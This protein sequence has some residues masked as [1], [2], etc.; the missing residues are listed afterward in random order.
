MENKML[1]IVPDEKYLQ[2]DENGKQFYAY[3]SAET[4]DRLTR[5]FVKDNMEEIKY[6]LNQ[7][8]NDSK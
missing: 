5:Q 7:I 3:F 8:E 2:T 4:I 1:C 6:Y